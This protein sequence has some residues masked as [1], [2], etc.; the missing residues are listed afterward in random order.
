MNQLR[1]R[2]CGGSRQPGGLSKEL[3]TLATTPRCRWRAD[4]GCT[5]RVEVAQ[6]RGL[7]A[8]YNRG[9]TLR[10]LTTPGPLPTAATRYYDTGQYE[11]ALADY[12]RS[13]ELRHDAPNTLNNR[14][15]TLQNLGRYEEALADYNRSLEMEPDDPT[16]LTN[17]GVTLRNLGRY[18]EALADYNRS[19]ELEPDD[20]TTLTNR[21]VMLTHLGRYEEALADFSRSLELR[22]DDPVTLYNVACLYSVT[23]RYEE[24][25]QSLEKAIAG[26]AKYRRMAAED[27]DFAP[28]RGHPQY[29]PQVQELIA[30]DLDA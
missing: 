30:G 10:A 3:V 13:L 14:G 1:R 23:G 9:W 19:L 8:A 7:L 21:G 12:N 20:T 18:E 28:L 2:L 27:E 15:N 24:A 16:T 26:D 6:L 11:E 17:R 5:G 29:G 4:P 25:L 22:P